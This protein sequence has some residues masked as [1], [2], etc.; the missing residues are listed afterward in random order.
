MRSEYLLGQATA[1]AVKAVNDRI[2]YGSTDL[3]AGSSSLTTGV[4]YAYY[5]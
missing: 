3:T 1:S 4:L 5:T 2:T